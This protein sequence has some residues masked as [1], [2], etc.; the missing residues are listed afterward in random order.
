M[1][2]DVLAMNTLTGCLVLLLIFALL[3]YAWPLLL[4]LAVIAIIYQIYAA[5][6]FKSEKFNTIKEKI[7]THIHDCNDLNDHIENLKSTALVVNRAD[8]GE[9]VYHD[10]SRWNVKRDAL[11][12]Q[13]YAPLYL[14]VLPHR[15]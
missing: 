4:V 15:L 6:Y 5:L 1:K 12:K 10:N 8:Y 7:Q 3:V 11:K 9:A 14:R 13:V 2:K